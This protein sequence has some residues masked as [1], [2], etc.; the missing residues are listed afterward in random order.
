MKP[1][2]L[3]NGWGPHTDGLMRAHRISPDPD[4]GGLFVADGGD[5]VGSKEDLEAV[6]NALTENDGLRSILQWCAEE[7]WEGGDID[8]GYF[9]DEMVKAGFFVEVP[10]SE[11]FREEW[12]SDTMYV[13]SWSPLAGEQE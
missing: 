9:Q 1:W 7:T 11:E 8:W 10:A 5:I 6:A 4:K 12:E 3:W 2:K 13:L